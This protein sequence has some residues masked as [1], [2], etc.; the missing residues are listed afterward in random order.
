MSEVSPH[1]PETMSAVWEEVHLSQLHSVSVRLSQVT[2]PWTFYFS[3]TL[4]LHFS[5]H[6]PSCC[7]FSVTLWHPETLWRL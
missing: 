6:L 5:F 3:V 7:R 1:L 4:V 2:P